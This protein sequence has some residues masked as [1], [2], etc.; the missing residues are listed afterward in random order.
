MRLLCRVLLAPVLAA[1]LCLPAA[2]ANR[3][4]DAVVKTKVFDGGIGIDPA[5]KVYPRLYRR[6]LAE[7]KRELN[8]WRIDADKD[9]KSDP[10]N[11]A[12]GRKYE[13]GRAYDQRSAIQGYISI[14]LN[15]YSDSGGVHPNHFADTLLW[16]VKAHKFI[17]IRPFFKETATNGPTMRTLATAI[18]KAV[19]AEKIKRGIPAK[20]ATDPTWFEYLK[21]DLTK[22]GGIALAPSTAHD[23]SSGLIAYFSPYAVGSYAEGNYIVFVPWTAFKTHLSAAGER[24]FGGMRPPGDAKRYGE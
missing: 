13:F 9:F 2:A 12:N 23:K 15:D 24:L 7:G 19:V 10:G 8:K 6:L 1:S 21:P 5:L 14:T 4:P 20:E 18:K 3:K 16:D 17:S 22:I 11:F